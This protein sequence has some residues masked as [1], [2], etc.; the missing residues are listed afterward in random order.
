VRFEPETKPSQLYEGIEYKDFW[1]GK[2]KIRLDELEHSIVLDL[3]PAS[4]TRIVDI[5]CGFGRLADCYLDRFEQVVMLDGSMTLLLQARESFKEKAIYIAADA[6]KLPFSASSFDCALMMRVFHHLP[7]SR[8]A[9]GGVKR[10]LGKDGCLVFNYS[11]KLSIRQLLRRLLSFGKKSILS[12]A[13]VVSGQTLIH[14]HPAYVHQ[15]LNSIGFSPTTYLGAGIMDKLPDKIGQIET[16]LPSGKAMAPLFGTIKVAPWIICKTRANEGMSVAKGKSIEDILACPSC[17]ASLTRSQ[18]TYQC[19]SCS[20]SYP[21]TDGI[22][23]F[24]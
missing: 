18:D 9:L 6:N 19:E 15:I 11:N 7:D 2:S 17:H 21:I 13:P 14:H 3:L 4:G 8:L 24:R 5:G 22:V 12:Q 23:D 16:R 10:V 1:H 20:R